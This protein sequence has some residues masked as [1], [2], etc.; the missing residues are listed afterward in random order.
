ML[1]KLAWRNIWRNKRRTFITLMMI[2]F[3]V[4]LATFMAAFR[5][6]IMESQVANVVGGFKGYGT[7]NDTAFIKEPFIDH[8]VAYDDSTIKY[9]E[10]Q[11][12]ISA[13]S[14]RIIGGGMLTCGDKFKIIRVTGVDP[15]LENQ[16]THLSSALIEGRMMQNS[17]EVVLGARLAQRIKADIDSTV[18][19]SGLGYHGNSANMLL[20]VVGIVKL[21]NVEEDKRLALISLSDAREG[22]A[23]YEGVN[24]VVLSFNDNTRA[25]ETVNQLKSTFTQSSQLYAWQELNEPLY[26]LVAINDAANIIISAMLYFVISFGLFGTILMMLAERKR[27]FGMLIALG[28]QK[29]KLGYIV[30][31]E[32]TLLALIGTAL[33]F[34]IAVPL[35]FYFNEFPLDI[36]GQMAEDMEKY[37]FQAQLRTSVKGIIF[38]GQAMAI[39]GITLLFSSYPILKIR[40]MDAV[41]AMQS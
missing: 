8:I 34:L 27:E 2:Q 14:P 20:R 32:N 30:Y 17:G 41:K 10:S 6:G 33:G 16:L 29:S 40:S 9:L 39:L 18:Y 13:Y 4:V 36:S 24:Q 28:M 31:L 5:S 15:Y 26:M 12:Q 22:F 3:A 1:L 25:L 19:F 38:L 35:I 23:L 11:L 7:I 21:S 37:G